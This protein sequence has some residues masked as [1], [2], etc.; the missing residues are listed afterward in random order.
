MLYQRLKE[1]F[2]TSRGRKGSMLLDEEM[3]RT[4]GIISPDEELAPDIPRDEIAVRL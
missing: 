4:A 2:G 3:L 1:K